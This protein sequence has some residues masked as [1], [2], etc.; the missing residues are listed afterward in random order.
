MAEATLSIG[1]VAA[2]AGVSVSA[3]RYY[4]RRGLMPEPERVGGQRRYRSAAVQRLG[5]IVT[6][7][8]A[9]LTLDEVGVLLAAADDG[10]P[11]Y[12]QLQGLASRKLPQV[13][14]LIERAEAMR[15]W[16]LAAAEC[17]CETLSA[18]ALFEQR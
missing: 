2:R 16:L 12:V 7:K 11:A 18:C 3:V 6:A 8:Q 15:G 17:R 5:V 4:E 14:A 9:G 10:A 1:E 13:D